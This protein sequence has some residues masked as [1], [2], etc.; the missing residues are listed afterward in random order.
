MKPDEGMG[1]INCVEVMIQQAKQKKGRG[2]HHLETESRE[3]RKNH[4]NRDIKQR[5]VKE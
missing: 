2:I 5:I 3:S 1:D 4:Q